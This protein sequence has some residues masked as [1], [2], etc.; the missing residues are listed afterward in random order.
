MAERFAPVPE[1]QESPDEP[2]GR[3]VPSVTWALLAGEPTLCSHGGQMRDFRD[4][5]DAGAAY[6]PLVTP[7][8]YVVAMDGVMQQLVGAPRSQPDWAW[9][10]PQEAARLFVE[11]NAAFVIEEPDFAFNESEV[12]RR[13][14][15]WPN[16][17]VK[18]VG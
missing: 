2:P 13:V 8:S 16:A 17:F 11:E 7:D 4:S 5:R 15:Y 1:S 14:T 10:N 9:N 3:L 6:A 12:R 18:R